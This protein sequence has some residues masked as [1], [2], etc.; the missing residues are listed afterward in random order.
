MQA[1]NVPR[2]LFICM[3]Q[4]ISKQYGQTRAMPVAR[5][6]RTVHSVY[7]TQFIIQTVFGK[8]HGTERTSL[9]IAQ[10]IAFFV[11]GFTF[12]I[13]NAGTHTNVYGT[14]AAMATIFRVVVMNNSAGV[15]AHCALEMLVFIFRCKLT[16]TVK[17]LCMFYLKNKLQKPRAALHCIAQFEWNSTWHN[18][19]DN[20]DGNN[21][22]QQ[23]SRQKRYETPR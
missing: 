9:K 19:G 15:C 21:I 12:H 5:A 3:W 23:Q 13:P 22:Q 7:A 1:N 6:H 14:I 16:A 8:H 2:L 4:V 11:L 18:D 17:H 10:K 20:D